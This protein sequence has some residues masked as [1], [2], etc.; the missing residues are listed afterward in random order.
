MDEAP[1]AAD[2]AIRPMRDDDVE[3]FVGLF[4][5][6]CAEGRW[7]ATEVPFEITD[8]VRRVRLGLRSNFHVNAQF[9]AVERAGEAIVGQIHVLRLPGEPAS[10]TVGMLVGPD[11][12]G[13]GIGAALLD[14][15]LAWA[16][17]QPLRRLELEVFPH[18]AA[19]LRLYRSRGF[20]DVELRRNALPR[21]NG[22]LWDV[23]AM[24]LELTARAGADGPRQ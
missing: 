24:R 8:F 21:R 17:A 18:N 1:E 19:A 14:A 12:R 13:R 2:F 6:V 10:A 9:V 5:R 3:A 11:F 16:C 15:A 22:E 20:R 23:L 4:Y 7:L